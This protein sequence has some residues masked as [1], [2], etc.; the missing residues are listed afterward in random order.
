MPQA[1]IGVFD[2]GIGG[3]SVLRQ[4]AEHLPGAEFEYVA[5]TANLPYG[6]KDPSTITHLVRRILE[7]LIERGARG[8][9]MACNTSSAIVLPQVA[10]TLPVPIFG[11]VVP[12]IREALAATRNRRIGVLA[13][14]ATVESGRFPAGFARLAN[15]AEPV[16][17]W[18]SPCPEL[19]PAIERGEGKTPEAERL[20]QGYLAPLLS[21]RVDT[22][23]LGCTHY[24]FWKDRMERL[25]P[26][27][28]FV[29]PAV[30]VALEVRRALGK[31]EDAPPAPLL[32]RCRFWT[33]GD[34]APFAARAATLLGG[35]PHVEQTSLRFDNRPI[36]PRPIN[37][38]KEGAEGCLETTVGP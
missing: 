35:T 29:D 32:E 12:G 6:D 23:L 33:T 4:L 26:A 37:P 17:V 27:V 11:V 15:P 13:N 9:V 38:R 19:V 20:L 3:L 34:P 28:R 22:I 36:N 7:F 5:D 16:A 25:A 30:A 18:Q 31:A 10:P 21:A 14:V 8:L 2:S 1:P 24:P